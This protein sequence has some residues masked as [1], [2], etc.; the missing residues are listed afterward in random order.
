MR[1]FLRQ[2]DRKLVPALEHSLTEKLTNLGTWN[3]IINI[4]RPL[5]LPNLLR[6]LRGTWC[7]VCH[8]LASVF[9]RGGCGASTVT[10]GFYM[11]NFIKSYLRDESGAAAAEYALILAIITAGIVVAVG[12]LGTDITTAITVAAGHI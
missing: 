11:Q 9:R 12:T 5:Q 4:G 6:M 10:M 8:Q 2:G 1:L 3:F 7:I